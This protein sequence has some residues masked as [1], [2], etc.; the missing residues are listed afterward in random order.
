ML[1]FTLL[2]ISSIAYSALN[3]ELNITGDLVLR[4]IKD[5]RITS[6][7]LVE[8]VNGG[9]EY[10]NSKYSNN[11]VSIS[12]SL[13]NKGSAITY[14]ATIKNT[15]T[16]DMTIASI[17]TSSS[18][19]IA[20]LTVDGISVED[21]RPGIK[22]IMLKKPLDESLKLAKKVYNRGQWPKFY[23]TKKGV[24]KASYPFL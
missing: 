1:C 16:V 13:P 11:T 4:S 17:N 19:D 15:G 12:S 5:I 6:L 14:E 24:R 22:A 18:N 2:S 3:Q 23:F 9:Y 10:Y 7:E 21:V 8:S 20:T